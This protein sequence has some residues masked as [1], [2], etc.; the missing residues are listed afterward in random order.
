MK[1]QMLNTTKDP[2]VHDYTVADGQKLSDFVS[3]YVGENP[4]NV[5]VNG[6]SETPDYVLSE[7]D[8]IVVS[9]MSGKIDSGR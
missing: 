2:Y 9:K 4:P 6:K 5:L 3:Q 8:L 1:V 7:G